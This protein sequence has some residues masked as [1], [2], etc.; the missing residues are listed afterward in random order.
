MMFECG[1]PAFCASK[2][3]AV[4]VATGQRTGTT[5][6]FVRN[7]YISLIKELLDSN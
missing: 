5:R 3:F 7:E 2:S 6:K 4:I 1:G